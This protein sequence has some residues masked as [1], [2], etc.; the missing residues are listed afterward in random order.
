MKRSGFLRVLVLLTLPLSFFSCVGI[1]S[2]AQIS[3]EGSGTISA[4]YRLSKELV[5]FGEQDSNKA[6]LPIPLTRE[7]LETS[8]KSSTGL[9]L[10]SWSSRK[11]GDDLVISVTIAFSDIQSLIHFL[12]PKGQLSNYKENGT[13]KTL[14]LSLGDSIPPL[15][16]SMKQMALD[17]FAPYSMKFA[18]TFP[19]PPKSVQSSGTGTKSWIEGKT[20]RF[21]A[22]MK[23]VVTSQDPVTWK[24]VW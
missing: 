3:T 17:A 13:D 24:I 23:D 9:S 20:A 1:D 16:P 12:D 8:L 5:S 7:D 15:D 4:E 11:D 19:T 14:L 21:E 2:R 6:L 18:F 10:Q 22:A